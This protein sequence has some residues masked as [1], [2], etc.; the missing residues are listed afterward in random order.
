MYVEEGARADCDQETKSS[1][2]REHGN[3][4]FPLLLVFF[5]VKFVVNSVVMLDVYSGGLS[6]KGK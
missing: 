4:L 2:S 3:W 1:L 6:E 5:V